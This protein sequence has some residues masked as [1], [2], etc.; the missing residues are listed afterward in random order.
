M[1]I[2]LLHATLMASAMLLAG[3]TTTNPDTGEKEVSNTTKGAGIGAATGAV[4]GAIINHNDRAKG[5]A[6]GAA[7]GG[8]A[9][10]AYGYRKDKQEA[11]LREQLKAT[12]IDV[13]N[14]GSAIKLVLPGNVSFSSGRAE[15]RPSFYN[16]LNTVAASLKSYPDTT[17]VIVGHTDS[18]GSDDL[19][20]RL[21]L[22]R[23]LAVG[24]YLSA[25]GIDPH[26]LQATGL[27][28]SQP[29][30]D[31]G[32]YRGREQNRRVE[33]KIVPKETQAAL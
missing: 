26:R 33:I 20:N 6:I 14:D 19:N 2:R 5:A 8:G 10:A 1:R 16:E 31:N 12:A 11:A 27:G 4:L 28:S 3:C 21:S 22:E 7:I 18:Q 30:A 9:G 17:V 29:V 25:Q 24:S 15:I 13:E 32:S 23:A